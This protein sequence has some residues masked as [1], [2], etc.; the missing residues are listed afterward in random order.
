MYLGDYLG[1]VYL[2]CLK[3]LL[4]HWQVSFP[5]SQSGID[6]IFAEVITLA[7]YLES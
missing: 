5:I 6:I 7:A 3:A 2:E 1:L 4:V